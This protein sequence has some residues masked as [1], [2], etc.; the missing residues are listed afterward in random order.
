MR[1]L[2][3]KSIKTQEIAVFPITR[4]GLYNIVLFMLKNDCVDQWSYNQSINDFN[5]QW[6]QYVNSETTVSAPKS[7][8]VYALG[9]N[10]LTWIRNIHYLTYSEKRTI[11]HAIAYIKA[12]AQLDWSGNFPEYYHQSIY[13]RYEI[14]ENVVST[15]FGLYF[16]EDIMKLNNHIYPKSFSRYMRRCSCC[17]R[18]FLDQEALLNAIGL[19]KLPNIEKSDIGY[20]DY[21]SECVE[22][23]TYYRQCDYCGLWVD[24]DELTYVENDDMYV[25]DDYRDYDG[26]FRYCEECGQL[27]NTDNI[28]GDVWTDDDCWYC[29]EECAENAGY[30]YSENRDCWTRDND[31]Y[32]GWIH[33]YHHYN[34]HKIVLDDDRRK[35]DL[36]IGMELEID[37]KNYTNFDY[38]FFE[39]LYNLYK[40][41]D[42]EDTTVWANDGSLD[43]GFE[44]ITM[45][46]DEKSFFSMDWGKA[47]DY[48]VENGWR[49][50]DTSSCGL[51][52]HFSSGYLGYTDEQKMDSAKKICYFFDRYWNDLKK[53]SR[54]SNYGYCRAYNIAISKDTSFNDLVDFGR[55]QAVNLTNMFGDFKDTIEIRICRGSLNT[56][57]QMA[58]ADFL[59]H[60]VRNAKRV[61]WKDIDNLERWFKGINNPNTIEYIKSRN[62]FEGAF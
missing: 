56:E 32:E 33:G 44:I 26:D 45:P 15:P 42:G 8:I 61:P 30:H 59:L 23:N 49:S 36:M 4:A 19:G 2:K 6:S 34:F 3:V 40:N 18:L 21:C 1:S 7:S 24:E 28:D 39:D 12:K 5:K 62:C 31:A 58:S 55:Y 47:N 54:R 9:Y 27:Y 20:D 53:F 52:F 51:H 41:E 13:F 22:N 10:F 60:I 17:G 57:T 37:G 14:F 16:A 25:C 29:S 38:D 48:L 35:Q 50:H 43:G 11:D 46:M